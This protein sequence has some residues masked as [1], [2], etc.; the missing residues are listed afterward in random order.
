MVFNPNSRESCDYYN[1]NFETKQPLSREEVER[2]N[3]EEE[4]RSI[5]SFMP[6]PSSLVACPGR[7]GSGSEDYFPQQSRDYALSH[8]ILCDCTV[9]PANK[10][11]YCEV[12]SLI[13]INARGQCKT[14]L[15]FIEK[16]IE[17]ERGT[18]TEKQDQFTPSWFFNRWDKNCPHLTKP[19]LLSILTNDTPT[20]WDEDVLRVHQEQGKH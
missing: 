14:G 5:S 17:R 18:E 19:D 2:K 8:T 1:V 7:G 9:C 15:S 20:K 12:P 4:S 3:Y 11:S 16:P 10:N 6:K 13:K